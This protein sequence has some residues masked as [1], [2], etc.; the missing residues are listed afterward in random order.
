LPTFWSFG[1]IY[2]AHERHDIEFIFWV[3]WLFS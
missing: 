3:L 2:E 1:V